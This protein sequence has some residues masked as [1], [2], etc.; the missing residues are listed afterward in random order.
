MP[1]GGDHPLS[2]DPFPAHKAFAAAF[3]NIDHSTFTHAVT[4]KLLPPTLGIAQWYGKS[5]LKVIII[6]EQKR[7][8]IIDLIALLHYMLFK[9]TDIYVNLLLTL[10]V[11]ISHLVEMST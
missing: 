8:C 10:R 3:A 9:L 5:F 6:L 2:Q 11:H 4:P 7:P 1:Y